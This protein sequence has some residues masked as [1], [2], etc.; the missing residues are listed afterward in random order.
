MFGNKSFLVLGDS[1]SDIASLIKGGYEILSFNFL[2]RQGVDR[3]GKVSTRVYGEDIN[4]TLSQLPPKCI[5]EWGI[6]S[7]EYR[8]GMI[9]TLDNENIPI[10][11]IIFQRAACIGFEVDYTQSGNSYA[12]TKIVIRA[13]KLIVGNDIDFDNEWTF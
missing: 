12:S 2:F 3:R 1:A 5:T 6:K 10:E 8:D 7:K 13:E 11:K 4:V 9:V